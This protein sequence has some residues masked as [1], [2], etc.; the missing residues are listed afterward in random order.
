[1]QFK[2]EVKSNII[3]NSPA[4]KKY[5]ALKNA[6]VEIQSGGQEMPVMVG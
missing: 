6:I 3:Q 1:M 5:A 4:V 2:K